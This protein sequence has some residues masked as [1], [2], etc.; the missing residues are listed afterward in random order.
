MA[1]KINNPGIG[2]GHG[3]R[4]LKDLV[5]RDCGSDY[6][7]KRSDSFRCPDCRKTNGKQRSATY[8]AKRAPCVD[9]GKPRSIGRERCRTCAAIK[10]NADYGPNNYKGGRVKAGDYIAIRLQRGKAKY[11][12]EHIAVWEAANG[13]LPKAWNVHHLNGIKHDNRLVNLLG[14]PNHE[15]HSHPHKAVKPYEARILEL[16]TRL[17]TAGLPID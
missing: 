16:E 3:L 1:R 2:T 8:E 5:C 10:R 6:Q 9:C 13:P 12:L 17:R 7:A 4:P 15:H 14:L 11:T